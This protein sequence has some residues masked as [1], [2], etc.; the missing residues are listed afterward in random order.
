MSATEKSCLYQRRMNVYFTDA[1]QACEQRIAYCSVSDVVYT[2][3]QIQY[4]LCVRVGGGAR[5]REHSRIQTHAR[6]EQER[7]RERETHMQ[8]HNFVSNLIYGYNLYTTITQTIFHLR[9]NSMQERLSG[10]TTYGPSLSFA[11]STCALRQ[12]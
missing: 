9:E 4:W 1:Q 12:Q 3:V 6:R 8:R 10:D 11:Y 7:E 5:A 2:Y